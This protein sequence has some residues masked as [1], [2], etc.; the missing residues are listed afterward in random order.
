[1]SCTEW[2]VDCEFT[3]E[4]V[5]D[6]ADKHIYIV[7]DDRDLPSY[8]FLETYSAIPSKMLPSQEDFVCEIVIPFRSK[9]YYDSGRLWGPP[10]KCYEA[11][12]DDERTLFGNCQAIVYTSSSDRIITTITLSEKISNELFDMFEQ[13]IVEKDIGDVISDSQ[14]DWRY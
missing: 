7:D 12:G 3:V 2:D 1:M 8:L 4:C 11:E 10:E 6:M 14:E 9:G 5:L 13:Q